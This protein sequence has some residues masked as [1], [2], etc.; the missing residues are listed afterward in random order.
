MIERATSKVI[1]EEDLSWDEE[2][3]VDLDE[4]IESVTE[5]KSGILI[6]Q[7]YQQNVSESKNS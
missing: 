1:H 5:S 3:D 4:D 2:E 7:K 6:N